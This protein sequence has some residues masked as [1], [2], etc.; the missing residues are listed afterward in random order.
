MKYLTVLCLLIFFLAQN[1]S[2]K[3][4]SG[5]VVSVDDGDSIQV[6]YGRRMERIRLYGIDCPERGQPFSDKAKQFTS[7]LAFGK[8]VKVEKYGIDDYGRTIANVYLPGGR[9][10]NSE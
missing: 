1:V 10:L 6:L 4:T 5:K 8:L 7:S 3:R 2:C 9:C